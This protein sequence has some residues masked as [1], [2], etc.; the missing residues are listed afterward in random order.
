MVDFSKT[1]FKKVGESTEA[2]KITSGYKIGSDS[3]KNRLYLV[4]IGYFD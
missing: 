1:Y 2:E 4:F 3:E